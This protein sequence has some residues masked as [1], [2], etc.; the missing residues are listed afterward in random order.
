MKPFFFKFSLLTLLLAC[1]TNVRCSLSQSLCLPKCITI[2]T[3]PNASRCELHEQKCFMKDRSPTTRG[4]AKPVE[5]DSGPGWYLFRA[6]KYD[7]IALNFSWKLPKEFF[8]ENLEGF[9]I[10]IESEQKAQRKVGYQPDVM[11]FCIDGNFTT[12]GKVSPLFYYDC[13]GRF[14]PAIID[15]GDYFNVHITPYQKYLTNVDLKRFSLSIEIAVPKCDDKSLKNM[16]TC[17]N[18]INILQYFCNN[19]TAIL[20]YSLSAWKGNA[21]TVLLCQPLNSNNPRCI[22]VLKAYTDR[23]LRMTAMPIEIPAEKNLN[24]NFSV[25]VFNDQPDALRLRTR[26]NFVKACSSSLPLDIILPSCVIASIALITTMLCLLRHVIWKRWLDDQPC[27]CKGVRTARAIADEKNSFPSVYIIF[28]DDHFKHRDIVSKFASFL[29]NDLGFLVTFEM[30][31]KEKLCK[32]YRLWL[33][34]AMALADKILVIWSPGAKRRW[35]VQTSI[36][37]YQAGLYDLFTP[38]MTQIK[39]DLLRNQN[40]GKYLFAYFEYCS[41]SDIPEDF[42]ELSFCQFKLMHQFVELYFRLKNTENFQTGLE[43]KKE[44]VAF[45]KLFYPNVTK[46]GPILKKSISDMCKYVQNYPTWH[47]NENSTF[48]SAQGNIL[49]VSCLMRAFKLH[50]QRF[51]LLLALLMKLLAETSTQFIVQ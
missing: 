26:I 20:Q 37:T 23:P 40:V 14:G 34:N 25:E 16:E 5:V 51:P 42:R 3:P 27:P 13:Y 2:Q 10:L 30:W 49:K 31:D 19:R 48:Q 43:L 46:F 4:I 44:K 36:E 21:A 41:E 28:V 8:V 45:E 50:K 39:E 22:D 35:E 7:F 24:Q 18:S 38:V 1:W 12:L 47:C 32:N 29:Y 33:E 11:Y 9:Q 17:Q 15:P 6:D